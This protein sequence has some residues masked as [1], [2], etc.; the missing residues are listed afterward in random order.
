M[1]IEQQ[2]LA[3]DHPYRLASQHALAITY[4]ANGQVKDAVR[5]LEEVVWIEQQTLAEDHP[6]RLASQ[7]E[8]AEAYEA[9][10][11]VKNAVSLEQVAP[12]GIAF[13]SLGNSGVF[14]ACFKKFCDAT[15]E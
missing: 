7:H 3:E 9:N 2:T 8:L 10:V 12:S 5:V 6:A 11:R 1:R 4:R 15:K 13:T 14:F